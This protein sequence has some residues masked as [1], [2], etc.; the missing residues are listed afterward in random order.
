[1]SFNLRSTQC[2]HHINIPKRIGELSE[3]FR[4]VLRQISEKVVMKVVKENTK[5]ALGVHSYT[6]VKRQDVKLLYKLC[7][8]YLNPTKNRRFYSLKQKMLLTQ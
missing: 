1:M 6:Q 2:V 3:K 4:E 5:K 8:K 7:A